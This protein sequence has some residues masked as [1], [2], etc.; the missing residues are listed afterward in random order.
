M[1]KMYKSMLKSLFLVIV[2]ALVVLFAISSQ[3]TYAKGP[4]RSAGENREN[5][6]NDSNREESRQSTNRKSS[7]DKQSERNNSSSNKSYSGGGS[8]AGQNSYNRESRANRAETNNRTSEGSRNNNRTYD[9]NSSGSSS[10]DRNS[11]NRGN[12]NDKDN[13]TYN[14]RTSESNKGNNRVPERDSS[15]KKSSYSNNNRGDKSGRDKDDRTFDKNRDDRNSNSRERERKEVDPSRVPWEMRN[16]NIKIYERNTQYRKDYDNIGKIW[17][18]RK[19]RR[20]TISDRIKRGNLYDN[21]YTRTR[22]N[23][24]FNYP[25]RYQYY[26]YDYR[27]VYSYPSAYCYYYDYFPPFI[28]GTRIVFITPRVHVNYVEIPIFANWNREYYLANP[29]YPYIRNTLDDIQRAWERNDPE[30][31]FNYVRRDSS[32][33]VY[34]QGDY[35]YTVDWLDY[36]DMTRDA[37]GTI[38]TKSL[39]FE[40]VRRYN[41]DEIIAYARHTYYDFDNYLKTVYVSYTLENYSGRWYITEVGSS[42]SQNY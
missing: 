36:I 41:N 40:R 23:L 31:L 38:Q 28:Y 37:M 42:P 26:C 7:D 18:E 25:F 13:R 19:E 6:S 29:S 30:L 4:N 3:T 24:F 27:P 16:S 21:R 2:I 9:R 22:I 32:I 14:N 11:I 35:S 12:S 10:A 34:L 20:D 8:S 17:R 15:P 5:R 1:F 33:S 39:V